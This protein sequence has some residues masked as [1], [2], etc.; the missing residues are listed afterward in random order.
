[1][2]FILNGTAE[3]VMQPTRFKI[4]KLLKERGPSFVDQIAK[5]T[6]VHPRM[7]SHHIDVLQ[8]EKLVESKY[9]LVRVNDSKRDVAVRTCWVTAKAADVMKDVRDSTRL[10]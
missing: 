8:E 9:E 3:I 7:I 1:M 2:K 6:G 10:E 4:L 5:E